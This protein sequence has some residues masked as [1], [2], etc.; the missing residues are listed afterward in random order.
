MREWRS[1]NGLDFDFTSVDILYRNPDEDESLT[2]FE[3]TSQ[4]LRL[5]GSTQR[6][7]RMVGA[8]FSNED[9]QRNETY[10]IGPDYEPDLPTALLAHQS[11]ARGCAGR[12]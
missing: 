4:G 2:A 10:R 12:G 1:I 8:F 3:T 6:V 7:D 11:R 5:T 9:L